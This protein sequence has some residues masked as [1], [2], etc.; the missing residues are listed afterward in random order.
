MALKVLLKQREVDK[1][2]LEEKVLL[3]INQLI[4]P[5]L[6]KLKKR[7]SDAKVRAYLD[8]LE[9]NLNEIVSPLVRNLGAKFLRLS[10]TELDINWLIEPLGV[11]LLSGGK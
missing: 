4:F 10:H 2:E 1:N 9:S 7:K 3:N 11:Q 5:Y 8:I 6:E